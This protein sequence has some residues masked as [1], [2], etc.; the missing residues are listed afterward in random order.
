LYIPKWSEPELQQCRQ[1]ITPT[2]AE[3][4]SEALEWKA[5]RVLPAVEAKVVTDRFV[6]YGG[7]ARMAFAT[8]A[9]LSK[10]L[11]GLELAD[12]RGAQHRH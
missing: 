9:E 8:A 3:R 1:L 6:Q 4:L 12:D 11:Q 5:S 10:L 7:I 2:A